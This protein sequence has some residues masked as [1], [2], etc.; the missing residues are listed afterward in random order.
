MPNS[1]AK[2]LTGN[3]SWMPYAAQGVKGPDDDD[4]D[5][6]DDDENQCISLAISTTFP[7]FG[8]TTMES[9]L[10]VLST[11]NG[12]LPPL[13][14]CTLMDLCLIRHRGNAMFYVQDKVLFSELSPVRAPSN[15]RIATAVLWSEH[16]LSVL[17]SGVNGWNVASWGECGRRKGNCTMR[18]RNLCCVSNMVR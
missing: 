1:G 7:H 8:C 18:G 4:D 3:S 9:Y 12:E 2:S 14:P 5:D 16:R 15:K 11:M 13:T 6:D 10:I 17:E